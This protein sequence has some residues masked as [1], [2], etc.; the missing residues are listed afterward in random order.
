[1]TDVSPDVVIHLA[2]IQQ[3]QDLDALF[4]ANVLAA[5][6]LLAALQAR[7]ERSR[8]L[9]VGSAA[10]Y[11]IA[12]GGHEVV[13]ECRPLLAGTPYGVS[14]NIQESW[15]L[16]HHAWGSPSVVCVRPFNIMGPGQPPSLVP[17]AFL[18]QLAKVV[19]GTTE[20]VK[21]GNLESRRD[22]IDVRDVAAAVWA[23]AVADEDVGGKVFN[24][25]S[26]QPLRIADLLNACIRLAGVDVPVEQ[27]P[28]KVKTVDVPTIVGDAGRLRAA[29]GWEPKIPWERS[30][31]DTW[32]ALRGG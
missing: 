4:Q 23:L 3:G 24:I 27:D 25:A 15:A 14:K 32:R 28:A 30:L 26:G 16:V 13:D 12:T 1:V 29:T 18:H 22:F 11:G 2:G 7:E 5:H 31:E 19:D 17:A 8:V 10:Q 21:V 20:V 9:V 6:N